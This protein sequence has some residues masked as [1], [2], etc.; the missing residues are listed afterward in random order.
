MTKVLIISNKSDLTSDFVVKR[1]KEKNIDFYRFNTDELTKSVSCTL[2]LESNSFYLF[3][4]KTSEKINLQDI[5]SVYFRR[6]EL[7][8]N[9]SVDINK[10]E[11]DLLQ[12]EI[13]YTLEGIYKLLRNAYWVSPIFAIRE[14]ENKIYQL[15]LAKQLDFKIPK[16]IISNRLNDLVNFYEKNS[17]NCIIKPIKSGL[18]EE[19]KK[20]KVIF[21]SLLRNKPESWEQINSCPNF[22][23]SNIQKKGDVRVTMV[24]KKAFSTFIHSQENEKTKTDWRKSEK[25]LKHSRIEIT[26]ELTNKCVQ[27]LK[28]LNLKFGAIDFIVDENEEFTFLEINPNG[29]WA[30][31]EKITGYNI[32]SEITNLLQNEC[33]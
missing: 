13:I 3:D 9:E 33:F 5:S 19:D 16:S 21:T 11:L 28:S 15:E 20:S 2:D 17:C 6:P 12:N 31:I 1:L 29:Q 27:L 23:Q 24:G 14:A 26:T 4:L 7:P 18:I 32:S 8:K 25:F 10:G 30:W 22:F